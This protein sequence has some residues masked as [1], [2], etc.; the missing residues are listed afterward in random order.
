MRGNIY[1]IIALFNGM[2]VESGT[3]QLASEH[4]GDK[5]YARH[6]SDYGTRG[7]SCFQ[8]RTFTCN[9][10]H[11]LVCS[12]N[13]QW[14]KGT[15]L[16]HVCH[17]ILSILNNMYS[18]DLRSQKMNKEYSQ[19]SVTNTAILFIASAL[20]AFLFREMGLIIG[21]YTAYIVACLMGAIYYRIHL[22]SRDRHDSGEDKKILLKISL[23][24]MMNN[25]LSQLMYLIDVFVI[26]IV[27]PEETILA[28]YKVPR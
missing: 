5:D 10:W 22:L 27:A 26:G 9:A 17:A 4:S 1:C 14:S 19:M 7:G 8:C 24:S 21:H 18:T 23:I 13:D 25:G 3:L 15:D 28:S 16:L 12:A 11:W 2:G 20:F 6:I